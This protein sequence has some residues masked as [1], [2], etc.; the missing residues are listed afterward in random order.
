MGV[1]TNGSQ[2]GISPVGIVVS[3]IKC[4]GRAGESISDCSYGDFGSFVGTSAG[5]N[6]Q[7]YVA[8]V[9]CSRQCDDG[10]TRLVGGAFYEGRVEVCVNNQWGGICDVGWDDVDAAVVCRSIQFYEGKSVK[11]YCAN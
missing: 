4:S 11:S 10:I 7:A 8:G 3:D 6:G 2:Y 9:V 5:C 1:A